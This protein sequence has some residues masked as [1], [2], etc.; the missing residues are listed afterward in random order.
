MAGMI[1]GSLIRHMQDLKLGLNNDSVTV[2]Q[3]S[4]EIQLEDDLRNLILR[5]DM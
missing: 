5:L 1:Q 2:S 3:N 4:P